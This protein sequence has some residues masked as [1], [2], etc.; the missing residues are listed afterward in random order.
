MYGMSQVWHNLY[1]RSNYIF[2]KFSKS[3]THNTLVISPGE[4]VFSF[5]WFFLFCDKFLLALKVSQS[6]LQIF[7]LSCFNILASGCEIKKKLLF[8]IFFFLAT[9]SSYFTTCVIINIKILLIRKCVWTYVLI[10]EYKEVFMVLV[11]L[12]IFC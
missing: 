10:I 11:V 5:T 8:H 2:F 4:K 3:L 1:K 6:C 7:R 9:N 12:N